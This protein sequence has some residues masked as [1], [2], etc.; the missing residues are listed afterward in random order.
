MVEFRSLNGDA[1][2]RGLSLDLSEPT[3]GSSGQCGGSLRWTADIAIVVAEVVADVTGAS[4]RHRICPFACRV[5][6]VVLYILN[7]Y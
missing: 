4:I 6:N 2:G 3:S 5:T 1:L 7:N